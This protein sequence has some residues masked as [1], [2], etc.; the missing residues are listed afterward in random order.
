MK[1]GTN[2]LTTGLGDFGVCEWKDYDEFLS[3]EAAHDVFGAHASLQKSGSFSQHRV[4][5]LVPI[6]VIEVLEMIEIEHDDA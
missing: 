4:T 2:T 1:F 3:P 6:S 5:S